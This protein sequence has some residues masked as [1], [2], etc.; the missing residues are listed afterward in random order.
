[1]TALT[2]AKTVKR[3][4]R[5]V[6]RGRPLVAE[7]GTHEISL[8]EKGRRFVVSVPLLAVYELG[9]KMLAREREKAKKDAKKGSRTK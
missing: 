4:T 3:E 9:Y 5:A 7:I 6:Y 1:M 2:G 8:R